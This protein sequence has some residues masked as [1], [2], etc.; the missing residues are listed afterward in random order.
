MAQKAYFLS[1]GCADCTVL[2]L[3]DR[4]V[5]ID[6]GY[7][8]SGQGVS[9]ETDIADYLTRV[10]GKRHIDLLIVSHPHHDHYL[11]MRDLIGKVTVAE[12]WGCPYERR[13]GDSSL[14]VEDW[15]EYCELKRK[16]VPDAGK[17]FKVWKQ[18]KA[19]FPPCTFTVLGPR[20]DVNAD[21]HRECHDASVVVWVSTP[22][23]DFIVCG[24][25][26]DNELQKI[27]ADW[28]F[29]SCTVLRAS[30][31]GSE[32][33]A[34]LDF[35]KA[36]SPRDTVISTKAGVF[37]NLPSPKALRRYQENSQKVFRTDTD[38]TCSTPL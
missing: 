21:Q 38:G 23:N 29:S 34:D 24:D 9:R 28:Q 33:G 30:H 4:L 27:R 22:N 19:T 12:F 2:D 10:L 7:R 3:G 35:I 32:N 37:E 1:V 15:E 14:S 11:A 13:Y 17:R 8:R 18:T 31:H 5:M 6:C 16:L 36:V 26:S 20:K 25:A